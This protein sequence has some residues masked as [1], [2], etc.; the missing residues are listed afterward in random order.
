MT[1]T[2]HILVLACLAVSSFITPAAIGVLLI[3]SLAW[4]DKQLPWKR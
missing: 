4:Y 3:Y 2:Q 1:T